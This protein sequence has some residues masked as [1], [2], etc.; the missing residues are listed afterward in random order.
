MYIYI[1][2]KDIKGEGH[3]VLLRADEIIIIIIILLVYSIQ[4]SSFID[5]S[6]PS[7]NTLYYSSCMPKM[8][9]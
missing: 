4:C 3:A 8:F 2:I 5:A 7:S 9:I 6:Y 1:S